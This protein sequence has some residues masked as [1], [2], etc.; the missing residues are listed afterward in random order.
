[1]FDH[2]A[3]DGHERLVLAADEACGLRA[4]VAIHSTALGPAFGGCRMHTYASTTDAI[5]DALRLARGMTYKVAICELP[6]GGGKSVILGDPRRDKS[7]ALLLA[8]GRLVESLSGR[9]IIADD[10]GTTLEDL[11]T[12]R[13]ATL[14]TAAASVA[15]RAPLGVTAYGVLMAMEAAVAHRLGRS[16]LAGLKVAVQ[17]LGNVGLPLCR[18]LHERG[19]KLVVSDLDA[20]RAGIAAAELGATIAVADAIHEAPVDV[21]APCALGGV[22][23]D[24]TVGRLRAAIVCGGA[25]NQLAA[26]RHDAALAARGIAYVP[27]YLANAGGT[28]DFHQE[29]IDD[30]PEAVLAAVERI[31][32]ITAGVMA[33][34]A[35]AGETPLQAADRR[36]RER[37]ARVTVPCDR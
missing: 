37:L 13:G 9:Y 15:A 20:E 19:A 14:H 21:F 5:G 22:L 24:A 2:P 36:V 10:V 32:T 25:N 26:E 30:R 16:D 28:I 31:R 11:A 29:S 8:M 1:M 23:N 3:Y 7:P 34:A 6:L 4:I 35:A 33:A 18:Y 27:D 12:M 17:G